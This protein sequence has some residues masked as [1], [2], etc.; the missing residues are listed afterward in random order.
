LTGAGVAFEAFL[1]GAGRA[2]F[3]IKRSPEAN[4]PPIVRATLPFMRS[5]CDSQ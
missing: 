2:T 4:V 3:A 5:F 1:T